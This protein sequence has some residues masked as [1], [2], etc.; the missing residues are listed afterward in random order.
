MASSRIAQSLKSA[1]QR[2]GWTRETLAHHAG[3]S[4]AAITQ[5]E[6][7]RRHEV[8]ASSLVA[9]AGAL[10]VSVDYLVGSSATVAPALLKH[11]VLEYGSDDEYLTIAI[12]FLTEG[13]ARSDSVL[14]VTAE[15]HADLVRDALGNNAQHVEFLD[16]A[17]WYSSLRSAAIGYRAF[18]KERFEG[19][20]PWIRILGEPVWTGRSETQLADWFRYESIINVAFASSPA[21]IVCSYDTRYVP[22]SVLTNARR[23]HPEVAGAG[24]TTNP[25]Y[26]NPE[27]FLLALE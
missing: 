15:R 22:E 7:G 21:T 2:L 16:A 20:A 3:L 14:T 19:G 8:R 9:L 23:T 27:E 5:I 25:S 18:L 17:E 26:T 1:R 24:V 4:S 12:P 11:R 10:G 6:S 13:I